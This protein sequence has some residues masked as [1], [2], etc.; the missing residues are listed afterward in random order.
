[1]VALAA[2]SFE[3]TAAV[4]GVVSGVLKVGSGLRDNRSISTRLVELARVVNFG[5]LLRRA[6]LL[7][8][9]NTQG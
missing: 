6:R 2:A 7:I 3:A 1:M 9:L 4:F 8:G 5:G